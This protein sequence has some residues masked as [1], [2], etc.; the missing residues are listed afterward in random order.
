[1]FKTEYG[2][3]RKVKQTTTTNLLFC[4]ERDEERYYIPG[5]EIDFYVKGT[6]KK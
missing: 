5:T 2:R 6:F 4:L 3:R 1:M